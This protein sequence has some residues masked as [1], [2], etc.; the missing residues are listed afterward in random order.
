MAKFGSSLG[1]GCTSALFPANQKCL[2][3]Y[4]SDDPSSL[5]LLLKLS[6][7]EQIFFVWYEKTVDH[8]F[9]DLFNMTRV[10]L[11]IIMPLNRLTK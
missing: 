9:Y 8:R 5:I 11:K 1:I 3:L 7:A 10:I 6:S 2:I 4:Q